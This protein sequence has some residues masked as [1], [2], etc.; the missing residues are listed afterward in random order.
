ML[1]RG[2]YVPSGGI[3]QIMCSCKGHM[4]KLEEIVHNHYLELIH[5]STLDLGV[6]RII[7]KSAEILGN[8]LIVTDE[9]YDLVGYASSGEVNDPIWK[10]IIESGY[11]PIDIVKILRHEGFEKRLEREASPL[12]LTQGEFSKYIR[13]LVTE[14]R[15][16]GQLKAIWPFWSMKNQLLV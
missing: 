4:R 6:S 11:C 16:G 1:L 5:L 9:S 15:I 10:A 3:K 13:R 14:I 12:F 7:K 8:P 2:K